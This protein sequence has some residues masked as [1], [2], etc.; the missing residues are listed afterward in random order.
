MSLLPTWYSSILNLS[1]PLV[2]V[3]GKLICRW[4]ILRHSVSDMVMMSSW[5]DTTTLHSVSFFEFSVRFCN[6]TMYEKKTL[7]KTVN[8]K[9]HLSSLILIF[10]K[11][12][13]KRIGTENSNKKLTLCVVGIL[14]LGRWQGRHGRRAAMDCR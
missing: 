3:A 4:R 10:F 2:V 6:W 8:N 5:S 14:N 9:H 1:L 11:I 12:D 7:W 13:I